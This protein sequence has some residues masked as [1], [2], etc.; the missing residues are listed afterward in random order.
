[1]NDL[2]DQ[3]ARLNSAG[4]PADDATVAADLRRGR[5]AQRNRR[6][7]RLVTSGV[8]VVAVGGVAAAVVV[9]G[10]PGGSPSTSDV[11]TAPEATDDTALQ[12]VDYTGEQPVPG[13]E[14]GKVPEGFVLQ[15]AGPYTLDIARPGDT[16]DIDSF[17]G[18]VVVM[19]LSK[20]AKIDTTGTPVTVN[21]HQGYLV[22][23][24]SST[25]LEYSDGTHDIVIQE[26]KDLGLSDDQLVELAEG[27][28]VTAEAQQ[29]VG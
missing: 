13:F 14:V 9:N 29:G 24:D 16:S 11:A 27:V 19:L 20:D 8:A 18:K 21:G 17:V 2:T 22:Q 5:R 23:Q 26:W 12:L 6:L 28:T 1:M 7:F 10:N 4:S 15:A 25:S 3:L